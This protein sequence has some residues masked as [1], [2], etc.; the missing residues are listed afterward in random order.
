MTSSFLLPACATCI[1]QEGQVTTVA[2]NG[3]VYVMFGALA[4]VFVCFGAVFMTI[5]RRSRRY[6][7]ETALPGENQ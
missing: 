5:V 7:R 6:A 3:A 2:A 4:L 1:S